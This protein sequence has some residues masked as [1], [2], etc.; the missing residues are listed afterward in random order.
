MNIKRLD[1]QL[2]LAGGRIWLGYVHAF[3]MSG[4]RTDAA[5]E[6]PGVLGLDENILGRVWG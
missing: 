4:D 2:Q 3:S 6:H 5:P 1:S